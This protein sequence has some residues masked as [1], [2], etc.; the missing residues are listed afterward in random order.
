[1][2]I[3]KIRKLLEKIS[4]TLDNIEC[5]QTEKLAKKEENQI[6]KELNQKEKEKNKAERKIVREENNAK[7]KNNINSKILNIKTFFSN[8]KTSIKLFFEN[9]KEEK[10]KNQL[11]NN[12][13]K[14]ILFFQ[15]IVFNCYKLFGI[16]EIY[17]KIDCETFDYTNLSEF[18]IDDV[19]T[20]YIKKNH[21]E[22]SN[23]C[24]TDYPEN[25]SFEISLKI[26][27]T[28]LACSYDYNDNLFNLN[29]LKTL[30]NLEKE[31]AS[32]NSCINK[33]FEEALEFIEIYLDSLFYEN[34]NMAK[35]S[36]DL[37][38]I[39]E[40]KNIYKNIIVF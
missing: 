22:I 9:K 19:I 32:I 17:E 34:L 33:Y 15:N 21:E 25:V 28:L 2:L 7:F 16:D 6:I 38:F 8:I 40:L 35:F 4:K 39:R 20:F 13:K 23:T 30:Y 31:N 1:M 10:T 37:T 18:N 24:V 27:A 11:E 3:N 14:E 12:N 26:L 36:E 5:K 29:R